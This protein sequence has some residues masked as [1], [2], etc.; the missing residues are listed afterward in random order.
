MR[1]TAQTKQATL[2]AI[3]AAG[4]KLF[5]R[6][7]TEATSTR[8]IAA[9]AKI[10][11][12]TLFNYFPSK[13]ALAM[14]LVAEAL[15]EGRERSRRQTGRDGAGLEED[16]FAQVACGIRALEPMRG[17]L[18]EVLEAGLSP[19]A[20]S[21]LSPEAARIRVGELE[22]VTAALSRHGRGDT[23][24]AAVLHLFWSL[25][26]GVLSFW[27]SDQSPKQEDT[28]ALLDQTV[29]MFVGGVGGVRRVGPVQ[30]RGR[31]TSGVAAEPRQI[32]AGEEANT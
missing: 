28:W 22:A 13:E 3:K 30:P 14:T 11:A 19:L 21:S 20:E 25:Y 26:L 2:D 29:R 5:A 10:A 16:L 32:E 18:A 24:T 6:K 15:E 23:A 31:G 1:V 12:G 8:E 17:Y 9:A 27:S 4:R 7:G